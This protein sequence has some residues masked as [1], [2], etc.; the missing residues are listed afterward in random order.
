MSIGDWF[1][2]LFGLARLLVC[3]I[4]GLEEVLSNDEVKAGARGWRKTPQGLKCG[5]CM[6]LHN[7]FTGAR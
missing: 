2:I 5:R 1:R 6:G 7:P 3:V 4:C